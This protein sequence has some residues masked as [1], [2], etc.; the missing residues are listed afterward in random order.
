MK[1][2]RTARWALA[3]LILGGAT[4]I[5]AAAERA[6][7]QK[8]QPLDKQNNFSVTILVSDEPGEA[9]VI[10]PKLVNAWGL[11]AGPQTPWWVADNGMDASTIYDG[12]GNKRPLEVAVNGAPTGLIFN[13]SSQFQIT[14]GSPALFIF[15]SESGSFLA[16][17]QAS[18]TTAM[19][20]PTDPGHGYKGLAILGDTLYTTDFTSCEVETFAGNFFDQSFAEF[21]TPGGFEDSSIPSGFCPFGIQAV[22]GS[23][24]VTYAK[25]GGEDDVAGV[26]NGFVREFDGDGNLVAKVGSHGT[27]N[28][29]WGVA[30]APDDFGRFSGCLLVGNFGDG[31]INAFCKNPAGQWHGAGRLHDGAHTLQIDGLWGI[32][33]GNGGPSGDPHVLYFAAGPDEESHGYFGEVD[34]VH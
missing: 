26:G 22:G 17:N 2:H 4:A 10:D 6:P 30:M 3:A 16:W 29:P 34:F 5:A 19:E 12:D 25:K 23:I 15:V 13:T 31:K 32:G 24:F 27:L 21:D 14:S 28:S 18:G 1:I 20:F 8:A 7:I 9:P 33:F 11:A